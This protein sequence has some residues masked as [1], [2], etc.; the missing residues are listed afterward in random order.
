ML[1]GGQNR[2]EDEEEEEEVEEEEDLGKDAKRR[3]AED[4]KNKSVQRV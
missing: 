2:Q 3:G 4:S 1:C